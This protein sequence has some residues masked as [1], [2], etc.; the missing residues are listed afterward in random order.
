MTRPWRLR[1]RT[2]DVPCTIEVEHTRSSLHAHVELEGI[3]V[4]PG[5]TVLVHDAPVAVGFGERIVCRRHATVVV[6]GA[7]ERLRTKIAA[8][9]ELT[10]LYEVS[11][12]PRRIP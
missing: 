3:E 11:F 2:L 9:F 12:T 7:L 5:D 8:F 6:A 1:S 10:E 4:G